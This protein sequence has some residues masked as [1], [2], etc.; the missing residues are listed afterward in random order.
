M[1]IDGRLLTADRAKQ[2]IIPP[3]YNRE[4]A[5]LAYEFEEDDAE[6]RHRTSH[7]FDQSPSSS[8]MPRRRSS[9][10]SQRRSSGT[11]LSSDDADSLS[12]WTPT[13]IGECSYTNNQLF[14]MSFI[15]FRKASLTR[16]VNI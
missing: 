13:Y 12:G 1:W 5:Q 11:A 16:I 15:S 7:N 14:G 8:R 6:D 2:F 10:A 9:G 3:V 4:A